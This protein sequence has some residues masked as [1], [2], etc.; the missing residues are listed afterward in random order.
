MPSPEAT[1]IAALVTSLAGVFTAVYAS[2]KTIRNAHQL[3][4]LQS[5]LVKHKDITLEYMKVYLTL[6]LEGRNQTLNAFKEVIKSVQVL[7]D[8]VR[9]VLK[10]PDSFSEKVLAGEMHNISSDISN[11]YATNQIFFK[12]EGL[13]SDRGLAHSLKN[14]C[15]TLAEMLPKYVRKKQP[16]LLREITQLQESISAK[17]IELRKRAYECASFLADDIR[18]H[19]DEE[20]LQLNE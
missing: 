14:E 17:Q 7:R 10:Y 6:E 3:A 4:K 2:L 20:V 18:N 1:I 16:E 19:I 5:D 13:N 12:D 8:N 15:C 9:R 11:A